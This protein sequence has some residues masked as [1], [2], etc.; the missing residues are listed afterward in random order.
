MSYSSGAGF[1]YLG[2]GELLTGTQSMEWINE[3]EKSRGARRYM[4]RIPVS[5][6]EDGSVLQTDS[7][8]TTGLRWV[9]HEPIAKSLHKSVHQI[10][11]F[12]KPV[13]Q[14]RIASERE[15][16]TG[17]PTL[18]IRNNLNSN[19]YHIPFVSTG[20]VQSI[21]DYLDETFLFSLVHNYPSIRVLFGEQD[22]DPLNILAFYTIGSAATLN[23]MCNYPHDHPHYH[24][25]RSRDGGSQRKN[26]KSSSKS[27]RP[28]T[29]KRK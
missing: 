8:T 22:L 25:Q 16:L 7:T 4:N 13:I 26:R 14:E 20:T 24:Q 6:G 28:I 23:L 2:K 17:K 12:L 29:R 27:G 1:E 3:T 9:P 10:T 5:P 15:R 21:I 19:V 18:F 11:Q